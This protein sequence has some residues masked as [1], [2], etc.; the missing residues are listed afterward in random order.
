[1]ARDRSL[2]SRRMLLPGL[3]G[4]V[5]NG[6]LSVA[7]GAVAAPRKRPVQ[8]QP[9]PRRDFTVTARRYS[10]EPPR[11]VVDQGDTVRI[12]LFAEDIPHSFT[13]DAYRIC[14]RVVP[15]TSAIVEFLAA[16]AGTFPFYCSLTEEEGCR[17]MRGELVVR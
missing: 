4:V 2:P 8:E 15:G 3:I 9:S 12:T 13:V 11:I 7:L 5:V 10:F 1:M 6:C 14:K 16:T 17:H